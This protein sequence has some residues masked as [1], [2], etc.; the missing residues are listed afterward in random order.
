MSLQSFSDPAEHVTALLRRLSWA[1]A[2]KSPGR[3][4]VWSPAD[5]ED[6][7]VIVPI[8]PENGDYAQLLERARRYLL[9]RYGSEAERIEALLL[10]AAA[11]DLDAARWKKETSVDAGLISWAEGEAI[12]TAARESL[13]AAARATKSKR[14]VQ[15]KSSAFLAKRF[16]EQVF[17]GQTEVGSFVVTAHVPASLAFHVNE[18]SERASQI[19]ARK[20]ETVSGRAIVDVF[21]QSIAAVREALT[22]YKKAPR[23][24][25][26]EEL[27]PEGVSLELVRALATLTR[28]GDAAVSIQ[29]GEATTN[30]REI[31]FDAIDA[32]VLDRVAASFEKLPEPQTVAI[33]GEV[34][35]L[36]NST[37]APV[38]IV[39][40][41]V[42]RGA[43]AKRVRVRLTP[44]QYDTAAAAHA[45]KQWLS[46]SGTLE[47]DG[48]DC[49]LYHAAEVTQ[50]PA[51][52]GPV[53]IQQTVFEEALIDERGI[54]INDAESGR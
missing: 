20:A 12:F 40:L 23:V 10:V 5:N 6:E 51:M 11:A 1:P 46:M 9:R 17:M 34:S 21:E 19:D 39:R 22:A 45:A 44:D 50:T 24:E 48:R 27:V 31:E 49:W 53:G 14:S 18:K 25:M 32:P 41:D 54:G 7:E 29:R 52:E 15:G 28:D 43:S 38:H 33:T 36:D 42:M 13:V 30:I 37:A 16:M 3:Y 2:S 47:K 35:L 4:E 26:F 8:N